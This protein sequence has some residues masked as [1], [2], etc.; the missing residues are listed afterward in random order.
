MLLAAAPTYGQDLLA[1]QAPIDRKLRAADSIS[2]ARMLRVESIEQPANDLYP[3][4]TNN[5]VRYKTTLPKEYKIDLRKFH[6]PCKSKIV[7]SHYG[8]RPRFGRNHYGTDIAVHIGDTI[9]A[10]FSGKVRVVNY[11]GKGY[12]N[13][14]I[15]RHPNGLETLYGHMSKHLV[16]PNQTVKAG[17][18]VGLGGSTGRSTGPHLHFETRFLGEFINP[19]KLFSF[20]N[21]DVKGDYYVFRSNGNSKLS[22][23]GGSNNSTNEAS[24]KKSNSNSSAKAEESRKFQEEKRNRSSRAQTH[25]VKRGESLSV[26]AKKYHTTVDKLCELNGISK[27]KKVVNEGQI[28]RCS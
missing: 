9:Y 24:A 28:L 15:I 17:Q 16:K 26:I 4:W 6:M 2:I 22:G 1:R 23:N 20:E 3:S 14:V 25:K 27:K 21:R 13:Y 10:A 7:T 19:E 11:E 5:Y 18:P 8:Y 12:G